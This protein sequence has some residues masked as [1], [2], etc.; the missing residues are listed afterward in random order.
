MNDASDVI[1]AANHM[2]SKHGVHAKGCAEQR[3]RELHWYSPAAAIIWREVSAEITK[4][5]RENG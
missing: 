4:I 1:R 2:I 3:V 5:E